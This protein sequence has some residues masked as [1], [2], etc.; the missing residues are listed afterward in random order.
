M[1]LLDALPTYPQELADGGK[2]LRRVPSQP[3][4][5]DD[6]LLLAGWELA[7]ETTQFGADEPSVQ[8]LDHRPESAGLVSGAWLVSCR[9]VVLGGAEVGGRRLR[10]G[11][12]LAG[13]SSRVCL[14]VQSDS[15]LAQGT[16]LPPDARSLI[17]VVPFGSL[18]V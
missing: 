2:G 13:D 9:V 17:D 12:G 4:V 10:A 5:G 1:Q 7:K 3:V 18:W 8:C 6:D 14:R 11:W 15:R 16:A